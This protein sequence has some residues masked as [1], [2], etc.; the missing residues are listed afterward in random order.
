MLVD[1][2]GHQLRR[3]NVLAEEFGVEVSIVLDIVHVQEKL[4]KA[5]R[6]LHAD[7]TARKRWVTSRLQRLLEGRSPKGLARGMKQSATKRGLSASA[8]KPVDEC[9]RYLS[10]ASEYLDYHTALSRGW[11]IATGVIEGTCRHL[12]GE[13]LVI[14]GAKWSLPRAE[15]IL[16]LRTLIRNGD[17]EAYWAFYEKREWERNHAS[18]YKD[19]VVPSPKREETGSDCHLRLVK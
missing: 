5:A 8:R 11:P 9:A 13:R 18:R 3:V 1:G 15:A 10:N 7:S 16:R 4:W 19:G 2:C 6:A 14:G 12:V 17:F